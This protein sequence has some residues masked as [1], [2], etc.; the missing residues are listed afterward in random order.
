MLVISENLIPIY[1]MAPEKFSL[2]KKIENQLLLTPSNFSVLM[3][4]ISFNI[5][6]KELKIAQISEVNHPL[7]PSNLVLVYVHGIYQF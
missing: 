3:A 1:R 7:Q 6:R 2:F 5:T 4:F